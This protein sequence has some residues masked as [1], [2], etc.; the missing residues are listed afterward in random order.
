MSFKELAEEY[1]RQRGD[2]GLGEET[3]MNDALVTLEREED[4]NERTKVP[5]EVDEGA[6]PNIPLPQVS[7]PTIAEEE[8][9]P[10]PEIEQKVETE[11]DDPPVPELPTEEVVLPEI[12]TVPRRPQKPFNPSGLTPDVKSPQE[13]EEPDIRLEKEAQID[14]EFNPGIQ[15]TTIVPEGMEAKELFNQVDKRI[16]DIPEHASP[17]TTDLPDL[18]PVPDVSALIADIDANMYQ[19]GQELLM[20]ERK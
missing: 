16:L 3:A 17:D 18:E 9:F 5:V 10:D 7:V 12:S 13:Y 2:I 8:D 19:A 20:W 14:V 4:L 11:H 6:A 1:F 15:D